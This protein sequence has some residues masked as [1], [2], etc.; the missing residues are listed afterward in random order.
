MRPRLL[1]RRAGRR[2]RKDRRG[3]D[4]DVERRRTAA[5]PRAPPRRWCRAT[6]GRAPTTA[7]SPPTTASPP[8][9][10]SPRPPPR[11][12]SATTTCPPRL[13]ICSATSRP[14]PLPPP[15]T[16]TTLRLNSF[17]G[18]IRCS[19]ASSSAQYSIRN[20]SE[21]RQRDVVAEDLE[22]LRLLLAPDLRQ[23]P[24]RRLARH[25]PARSRPLITWM[26]LTKNSVVIRASRLS[27]PK[28][29]SPRPGN[30]DHRRIA[31]AQ[32]R[33]GRLGERLVVGRVVVAIR[34]DPLGDPIA[35]RAGVSRGRI[36]GDEHRRD[37][38]PQEVIRTARAEPAQI[39]GPGRIG[40]RERVRGCRRSGRSRAGSTTRRRA[41]TGRSRRR[42][43]RDPATTAVTAGPPNT[44][45]ARAPR[46]LLDELAPSGRWCGCCS[47]STRAGSCPR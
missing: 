23:R 36:P 26:A 15:T 9:A 21:P 6:S 8:P 12:A 22:L 34:A 31:V 28:P 32:R 29:K 40:E 3:V 1:R 5:P 18:G 20:A 19:L 45:T 24:R 30:H 38:R 27:L 44:R 37:A 14:M 33:R 2:R 43:R 11:S 7:P 41:D 13:A 10:P 16:T 4:H 46:V 42:P 17:S 35:N 25:P 39:L 47:R